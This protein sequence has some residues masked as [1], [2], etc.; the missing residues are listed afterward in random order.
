MNCLNEYQLEC[1][2]K[3]SAPLKGIMWRQHLKKCEICQQKMDELKANLNVQNDIQLLF[4][5][6]AEK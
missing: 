4:S 1:L 2:I 6:D 3:Q 5:E